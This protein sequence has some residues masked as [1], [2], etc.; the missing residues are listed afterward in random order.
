VPQFQYRARD[1]QGSLISGRIE[2]DSAGAAAGRLTGTG[3]TPIV[4]EAAAAR[5]LQLSVYLRRLGIGRPRTVDLV[6]FSRQMYTITKSG[7]PLLRG[8]RGLCDSTHNDV[9]REALQD[10]ILSLEA[11]RDL[12]GSLARHPDIFSTL[13]VSIV[14]VGESTGTLDTA[15]LRMCEYLSLDQDV[16]D[17]VRGAM[18]YPAMVVLAVAAALAVIT[19]FV[20][21]NF[22]PIFRVL[23]DDLPMPTRII[24][25][26]S[27]FA[28][29]HWREVLAGCIGL[30]LAFRYWVRTDAGRYRWHRALLRMPAV[31]TMLHQA[32]LAR[33]ARSL[34]VSLNAGLPMTQ[35]L[36]V[37]GRSAGNDFMAEQVD[38]VRT[39]VERGES[40]SRAA[41]AAGM[42]PSLVVQMMGVGEETGELP[43]LLSEVA[44]YYEREVNHALKNLSATIEPT[45]IVAVGGIVLVLAL[46]VFLPLWE[47][48]GKVAGPA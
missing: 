36:A 47:M 10:V 5:A 16:Q 6:M 15:F 34:S 4:I 23:G 32:I 9:L 43:A 1:R 42:F 46:G 48:I 2:A 26:V 38:R 12:A 41:L 45:L 14:R 40:L 7:I 11:G 8:L 28:Q 18:R 30:W 33:V 13:Y 22:A 44:D 27:S 24:L 37:I 21:P 25:A 19:I 29:Q 20:I 35:T 39:S 3:V 17:R 31:G